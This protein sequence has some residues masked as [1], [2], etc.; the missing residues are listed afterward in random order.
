MYYLHTLH[1]SSLDIIQEVMADGP[2]F[3]NLHIL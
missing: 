1:N 2:Q 3:T